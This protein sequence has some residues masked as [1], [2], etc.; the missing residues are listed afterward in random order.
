MVAMTK[1]T[2]RVAAFLGVAVIALAWP[3]ARTVAADTPAAQG[4]PNVLV[5]ITDQQR[6]DMLSCTGNPFVKT[7]NLDSLA[8]NGARFERAY[9]AN[10]VCTPSRFCMFTGRLPSFIGMENNSHITNAVPQEVF[11]HAMGFVFRQA[12]Y[13]TVYG[14]KVHLPQSGPKQGWATR[15]GFDTFLGTDPRDELAARCDKFLR[16]KHDRPF[17]LVAS[18]MNPHDICYMAINDTRKDPKVGPLAKARLP[19]EPPAEA[20]LDDAMKLPAGVPEKEFFANMCP[21]LPANFGVPQNEIGCRSTL[22][23]YGPPPYNTWVRKNWTERDWRLH[24]WAYARLTERADGNIGVVLKALR[25]SGLEEQTLV[26]FTSDHGEMDGSHQLEQKG[27]PYEEDIRVPFL[28]SWK[29]KTKAGLVDREHL[30]SSGL[31]LIPT[32]CDF[33]GVPVPSDFKGCSVRTLAEG[34]EPAAAWRDFLVVENLNTRV[35]RRVSWKYVAGTGI[36]PREM[37]FDTQHDP[38]EMQ[39][40]ANDA[41]RAQLEE[42]RRLLQQW[43]RDHSDRLRERYETHHQEKQP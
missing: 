10:P 25:E 27:T 33:A 19:H 18:F 2:R 11:D 15:Y 9:C 7:P 20:C 36:E 39:S 41:H 16:E 26:V 32:I 29:G 35:V 13:Q 43:C 14:G 5:I 22:P 17:L 6:A 42:G 37:L 34:R 28:V 4:R 30:V 21:P 8:R 24:R 31:D 3:A 1:S 12:G 38:G 23:K 40:L